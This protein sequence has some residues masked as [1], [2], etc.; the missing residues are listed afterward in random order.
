MVAEVSLC[1]KTSLFQF[2]QH[3]V[4]FKLFI[5]KSLSFLKQKYYFNLCSVPSSPY[6][7]KNGRIRPYSLQLGRQIKQKLWERLNCPMMSQSDD[8]DGL[9]HV[10]VTYGAGVHPPLYD[11]NTSGEPSPG[12]PPAKR[13]K[14]SK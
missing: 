6:R 10:D 14:S 3:L 7:F 11:V 13:A 9:V 1:Y 4:F 2:D 12:R 5:T 8:E